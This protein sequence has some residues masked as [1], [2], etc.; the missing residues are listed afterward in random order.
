MERHGWQILT[1]NYHIPDGE[2]D[3]VAQKGLTLAFVEVKAR[4]EDT[5]Y[6]AQDAVTP[7]KQ[8]KLHRTA[9]AYLAQYPCEYQPRF[10]VCEVYFTKDRRVL[11]RYLEN[12]FEEDGQG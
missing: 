1:R 9:L 8:K 10:D 2:I 7:Q 3:I 11:I 12:A 6:A 4:A 5:R